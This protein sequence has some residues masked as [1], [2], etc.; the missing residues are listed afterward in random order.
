M[1]V[2]FATNRNELPD[3]KK[4]VFG[5][6]FNPDGVAALRFGHVD[7][8]DDVETLQGGAVYVY[9]DLK[10]ETD[11]AKTGGGQ[12][13]DD[14]RKAMLGGCD[15]LVFIHG[16]NVTFAGAIEAGARLAREVRIR[17]GGGR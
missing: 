10:G 9:P 5:P 4:L 8:P 7:F 14:L 16:F 1:R 2:Y 11:V 15:T 12:F 13:L 6:R 17:A 3:N